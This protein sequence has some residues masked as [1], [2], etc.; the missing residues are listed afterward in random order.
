MDLWSARIPFLGRIAHH[1]WLVIRRGAR[2]DR[3]EVW[4]TPGECET[5]WGY[6]HCNLMPLSSGVGNGPGSL[7]QRWTSDAAVDLAARIESSP[8]TY[9]WRHRYRAFPGPNSNTYVQWALGSLHKLGWRGIGRD[10]RA[11]TGLSQKQV[12]RWI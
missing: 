5:A 4:Q 3:W 11:G 7:L 9:P 1:H 2:A 10:Y 8:T 12:N 6:L